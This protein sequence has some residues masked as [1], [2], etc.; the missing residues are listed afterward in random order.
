MKGW[1]LAA[2]L[3]LTPGA[4][5]AAD[6]S[7]L[8]ASGPVKVSS[9][10]EWRA[11]AGRASVATGAWLKTGT[12]GR[13]VLERDGVRIEVR[14]R[15]LVA[16]AALADDPDM[17][18]LVQRWGET[19]LEVEKRDRPHVKVQ[20]PFLASVVK[21]TRF[22]ISVDRCY[23]AMNVHEGRIAVE[24]APRGQAT[25]ITTGQRAGAGR[26]RTNGMR[27]E[28]AGPRAGMTAIPK[29]S[30]LVPGLAR[31]EVVTPRNVH[32]PAMR[33]PRQS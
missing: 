19:S 6:W 11:L 17:K 4:T 25:E 16:V 15:S 5:M 26:G 10:G 27:I 23:T 13:V 21:G 2:M 33:L 9:G 1:V 3:A 7:V 28:G 8:S 29:A 24:D 31:H 18:V 14:P 32:E 12:K 22:D 20:T 30:G